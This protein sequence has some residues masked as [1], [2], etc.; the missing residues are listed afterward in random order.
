MRLSAAVLGAA[1][2]SLFS[3]VGVRLM[4]V[5]WRHRTRAE[6]VGREMLLKQPPIRKWV[7]VGVFATVLMMLPVG[8]VV[9]GP[10]N[11]TTF[12][13]VVFLL[14]LAGNVGALGWAIGRRMIAVNSDAI[15]LKGVWGRRIAWSELANVQAFSVPHRQVLVF[16]RGQGKAIALD[17]TYYGWEE[18]LEK[19]SEIAPKAGRRVAQAMA[20]LERKDAK[21]PSGTSH[22]K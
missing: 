11:P 22:A 16:S 6:W 17:S 19:V 9:R 20:S 21:G 12:P 7:G 8:A 14:G 18:F 10:S 3:F 4:N 5:R 2:G 1:V 15:E 13:M